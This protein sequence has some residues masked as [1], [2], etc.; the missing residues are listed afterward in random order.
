MNSLTY[1]KKL[2]I[3]GAV[4]NEYLYYAFVKCDVPCTVRNV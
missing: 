1:L 2:N 3:K 4:N